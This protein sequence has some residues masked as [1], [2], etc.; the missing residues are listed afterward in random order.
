MCTIEIPLPQNEYDSDKVVIIAMPCPH[1]IEFHHC[2]CP[3]RLNLIPLRLVI[4]T[5]S[6]LLSF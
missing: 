1:C 5:Q 2:H 4:A 3:Y 6:Y